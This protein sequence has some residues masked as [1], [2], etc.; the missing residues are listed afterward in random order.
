MPPCAIRPCRPSWLNARGPSTAVPAL[1][2]IILTAFRTGEVLGA[3]RDE[4]DIEARMWTP[5]LPRMKG[6]KPL[7]APLGRRAIEIHDDVRG[8]HRV[9]V[10]PGI[11]GRAM[12]SQAMW[13]VVGKLGREC[14]GTWLSE[15]IS[16]M[17]GG[18]HV[19][20]S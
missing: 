9:W 18:M 11:D 8:Q 14:H 19:S 12:D 3:G 17:G 20:S 15:R 2:F 10:F 7:R 1:E 5:G 4:I 13:R 6:G 16:D